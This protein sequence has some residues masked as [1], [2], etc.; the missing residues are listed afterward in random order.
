MT[1]RKESGAGKRP[2][3]NQAK[4]KEPA[5]PPAGTGGHSDF[6]S[7]VSPAAGNADG[8]GRGPDQGPVELGRNQKHGGGTGA[9]VVPSENRKR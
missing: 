7:N 6:D 5:S 1:T 8:R 9:T 3:G 2:A 4:N